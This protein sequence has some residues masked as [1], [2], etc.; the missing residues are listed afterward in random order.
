MCIRD[1]LYAFGSIAKG[2]FRKDSDI[3]LIMHLKQMPPEQKGEYILAIW[4]ELEVLFSRKVDLLTDQ[5]ILKIA[6]Y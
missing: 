4:D 3:D 5:K 1:R 6:K 2:D